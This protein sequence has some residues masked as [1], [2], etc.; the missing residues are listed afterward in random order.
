MR[1]AQ[2]NCRHYPKNE[3]FSECVTL[4]AQR[5]DR[6]TCRRTECLEAEAKL[7]LEGGARVA[8][9]E[10][11]RLRAAVQHAVRQRRDRHLQHATLLAAVG[12]HVCA[13]RGLR[14]GR[15]GTAR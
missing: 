5:R 14:P 7:L 9:L 15:Q 13:L 2:N 4:S 3:K 8:R 10:H 6:G 1:S 11:A 12:G